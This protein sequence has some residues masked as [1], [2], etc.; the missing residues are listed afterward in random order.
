MIF[1]FFFFFLKNLRFDK[2]C[3][4]PLYL[5][6]LEIVADLGNDLTLEASESISTRPRCPMET[7]ISGSFADLTERG[8][9]VRPR[10]YVSIYD[11]TTF[12]ILVSACD[13]RPRSFARRN[14]LNGRLYERDIYIYLVWIMAQGIWY[15]SL[16]VEKSQSRIKEARRMLQERLRLKIGK[17]RGCRY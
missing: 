7:R 17:E 5:R 8:D 1:F 13:D 9:G 10:C 3:P 12:H 11:A 4:I 16:F 14:S 2:S 15:I 6:S